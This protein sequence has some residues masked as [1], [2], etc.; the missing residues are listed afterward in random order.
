MANCINIFL[1]R[2]CIILKIKDN[3]SKDEII[4]NLKVKLHEIRRFYK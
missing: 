1:K 4:E 2:D 3:A